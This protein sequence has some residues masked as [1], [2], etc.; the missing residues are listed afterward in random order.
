LWENWIKRSRWIIPTGGRLVLAGIVGDLLRSRYLTRPFHYVQAL[1]ICL[2]HLHQGLDQ[3]VRSLKGRIY[4]VLLRHRQLDHLYRLFKPQHLHPP[5]KT[6]QLRPRTMTI[7]LELNSR[8]SVS[9]P[10][11][12]LNPIFLLLLRLYANARRIV[13]QTTLLDHRSRPLDLCS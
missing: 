13:H 6:I 4:L 9:A 1:L 2:N 3:E 10:S 12:H 5:V 7:L 11:L 8:A